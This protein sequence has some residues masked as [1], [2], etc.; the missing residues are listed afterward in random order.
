MKVYVDSSVVL[1]FVLR[2]PGAIH[3]WS[4]WEHAVTSELTQI[5]ARRTLDRLRLRGK[6]S[7]SEV[8]QG[9]GWLKDTMARFEE[10]AIQAPIL[11]RAASPCPT[12]L[13][14]LDAIHLATA[15]LWIERRGEALV[16]LTHDDELAI[17]ARASGL[18]VGP[19]ARRR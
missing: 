1:R 11:D 14:T 8:A 9:V 6:L 2:Q 12:S 18:V 13:G 7:D 4:G 3:R 5:E 19:L 15:L 16:F 17:A 10:V